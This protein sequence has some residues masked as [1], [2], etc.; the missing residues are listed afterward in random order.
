MMYELNS[1]LCLAKWESIYKL[2]EED[3]DENYRVVYA[4]CIIWYYQNVSEYNLSV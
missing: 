1:N 4:L 2:T 3:A